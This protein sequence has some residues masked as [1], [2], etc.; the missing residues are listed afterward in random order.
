MTTMPAADFRAAIDQWPP[1]VGQGITVP[2]I[3]E[4]V[5]RQRREIYVRRLR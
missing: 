4:A 3:S 5:A 1:F 2:E